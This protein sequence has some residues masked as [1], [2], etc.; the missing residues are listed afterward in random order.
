MITPS[1][2]ERLDRIVAHYAMKDYLRANPKPKYDRKTGAPIRK[3]YTLSPE[4][5][6]ARAMLSL[7]RSE[8]LTPEQEEI[9]KAYLLK[10]KILFDL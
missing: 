4:T 1:N 8:N 2:I 5:N 7:A 3:P 6:E 9:V 10:H